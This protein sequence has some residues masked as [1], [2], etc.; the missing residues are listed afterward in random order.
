[1]DTFCLF[2]PRLQHNGFDGTDVLLSLP[3]LASG[4]ERVTPYLQKKWPHSTTT[5]TFD[6]VLPLCKVQHCQ[7]NALVFKYAIIPCTIVSN[8]VIFL[9]CSKHAQIFACLKITRHRK[10]VSNLGPFCVL[11]LN[12]LAASC[13]KK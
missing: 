11:R 7:Y 5:R 12:G 10:L 1:V 13:I 6:R 2:Q 4:Y 3:L 8:K 9:I